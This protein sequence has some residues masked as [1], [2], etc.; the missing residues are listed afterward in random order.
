ME[1]KLGLNLY[2]FQVSLEMKTPSIPSRELLRLED[3]NTTLLLHQ[4]ERLALYE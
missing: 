3:M 1:N 2:L 4:D